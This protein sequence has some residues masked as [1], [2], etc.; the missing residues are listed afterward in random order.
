MSIEVR[1]ESGCGI[2]SVTKVVAVASN[3]LRGRKCM[4][5]DCPS[6]LE[7]LLHLYSLR[8][9]PARSGRFVQVMFPHM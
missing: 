2:F 9:K 7:L 1:E 6:L 4:E 5:G 3:M 8:E